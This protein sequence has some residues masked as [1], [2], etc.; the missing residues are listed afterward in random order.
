MVPRM[1]CT[2]I[3]QI[4]AVNKSVQK[5]LS[6]CTWNVG[7]LMCRATKY[8][9]LHDPLF[10][11]A[12]VDFDIIALLETHVSP[13][14]PLELEGYYVCRRDRPQSRNGRHFGGW[15]IFIRKSLRDLG[16]QILEQS[17]DLCWLKI[18]KNPFRLS[19]DIYL[20]VAYIPPSDSSYLANLGIDILEQIQNGIMKYSQLG[21]I[22]FTGDLNARTGHEPDFIQGDNNTDITSDFDY[23]VDKEICARQSLDRVVN[24]RGKEILDICVSAQMRILNGRKVGDSLGYHTCHKWNGS[25]VVDYA[26]V[27]E[28]LLDTIPF[29][30]VGEFM[31]DLSD[32]CYITFDLSIPHI[33]TQPP[34][35]I[36]L[37]LPTSFKWSCEAATLYTEALVSPT[38]QERVQNFMNFTY[39]QDE[40]GISLATD[41]ITSIIQTA[42]EKVLRK[43][44][45]ARGKAKNKTQPWFDKSLNQQRS[46]L[47]AK[48]H[49]LGKFPHDPLVRGNYFKH[50]KLYRKNCKKKSR[51][52]RQHM[53]E[54]LNNLHSSNPKAYWNLVQKLK[55]DEHHNLS[56]ISSDEWL[57]HFKSLGKPQFF[58]HPINLT[59]VQSEKEALESETNFTELDFRISKSEIIAGIRE[60]KNGKA[61]G[62][63]G[64]CN[65]ML[66]HG[67]HVMLDPLEKAF[68]L[69]LSTG[70]YP[71][72]WARGFIKPIHKKG[73]PMAVDNYRGITITSVLGKLFNAIINTRIVEFLNNRNILK[74]EQIGFRAKCRTA[75]HALVI[76][77][78]ADK[79][80]SKKRALYT[81][82][83]DFQKAFDSVSHPC[84]LYKLLLLNMNGR[85]YRIIQN[86]YS[87]INLQVNVG[88][89]LTEAF[90][91]HVGVRQGDNL[92]PTLFNIFVNDIPDT[93]DNT[94][95]PV[96]LNGRMLNCLLYADDLVLLSESAEGLQRAINKLQIYCDTWGLTVNPSKT[97]ALVVNPR[98]R[99]PLELTIDNNPIEVVDQ[100][101][102]LGLVIDKDVTFKGCLK[103]QYQK[104]L[105]AIFKLRR[106]LSPLPNTETCLHL[107]NHI[108]KPILLYGSEIWASSLFGVRNNKHINENNIEAFYFAQGPPIENALLKYCKMVLG[109]HRHTDNLAVY[110]EL[111]I[112]PLY[113][114]A[115][116]RLL[117]YWHNIE[118]I[119]ENA[120]LQ[121]AYTCMQELQVEGKNTWLKF[122]TNIGNLYG[123]VPSVRTSDTSSIKY[124]MGKLR[125]QFAGYWQK[126]LL[127]DIHAKSVHGRKLRTYRTFKNKFGPEPYLHVVSNHK[128]RVAL[129]QF[130]VS[131]HRLMIE[132][133][134]RSKMDLAKRLCTK[135]NLH[136]VEDEVHFL[137]T[138][139]AYDRQRSKL[140]DVIKAES[141]LCH[142]LD[143]DDQFL[144]IMSNVNDTVILAL[145]EYISSA[146]VYRQLMK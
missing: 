3:G 15:V 132:V 21:Q 129:T 116:D 75:D 120:L 53:I 144:W 11:K 105:K 32:H 115:I 10:L 59:K 46:R 36:I 6:F 37:P 20:C 45:P 124:L 52:F 112:Y 113:I 30:K 133:G 108:V 35:E 102:Y 141:P 82:F 2:N 66:K 119:S 78:L 130:R 5:S 97:K 86:L 28:S 142:Q 90:T 57:N 72:S 76:K 38:I 98:D 99:N 73:D 26:I 93:F 61:C 47:R 77:T 117:K 100:V 44:R 114:D 146:M 136:V 27:S 39:S 74:P 16:I 55:G 64:I 138:C 8:M 127:S 121:D 84:L 103:A 128:W 91:S 101:T 42:A 110:G 17:L 111:G 12:I 89:G 109:V 56:K 60:L 4:S 106:M 18:P 83:V 33:W 40:C 145:A 79:Y 31:A 49:L 58:K 123:H 25:S 80:K 81:C 65:E 29:F 54:T 50:L 94:C 143:L 41:Y 22:I 104:S 23:T 122:V 139:P 131:A 48:A 19:Q 85:V 134:R 14:D 7:G 135:C 63:D 107:F 125:G 126:C 71:T 24:T 87:K 68:N 9:K 95:D 140:K 51:Q 69:I 137:M 1:K 13:M 34:C 70:V 96:N 88:I 118:F 43:R 62:P 92:S 67:T